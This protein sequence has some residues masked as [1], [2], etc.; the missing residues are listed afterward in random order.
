[1]KKP[2]L[3]KDEMDRKVKWE[4]VK[5]NLSSGTWKGWTYPKRKQKKEGEH[6]GRYQISLR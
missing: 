5:F 3:D 4:E 6:N 1:M 2:V